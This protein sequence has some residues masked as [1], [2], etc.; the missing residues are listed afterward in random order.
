VDANALR[1]IIPLL[2]VVLVLRRNLRARAL[3]VERMWVYPAILI[4]AAFAA[5][6][7]E[8]FPGVVPLVGYAVALAAG[9]AIGWWR[10][11]LTQITIDPA[12]HEFTS[13]A[14]V[15]G[16]IL[17]GVVFAMKYGVSMAK[18]SGPIEMPFGG[19]LDLGGIT[20]GLTFFA[21]GTITAQ[22]VEMFLRC[23]KL[24][25]QARSGGSEQA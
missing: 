9:A 8:P 12:T 7:S 11:R 21:V 18:A 10:G 5:M 17:I 14:S 1:F 13:Q 20:Q 25:A 6:Q 16:V 2:I 3:K 19:R 23:Q 24:L 22:R 15:A 4:A